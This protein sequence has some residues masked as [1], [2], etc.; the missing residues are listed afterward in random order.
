MHPALRR[1]GQ[2]ASQLMPRSLTNRVFALYTLT[3][4]VF[5]VVGLGLFLKFQFQTEVEDTQAASVMLVEVVTQG[6]QDSVVIGDYDTVRKMLDRAVQGSLF[7]SATFIDMKGGELARADFIEGSC[8]PEVLEQVKADAA[9]GGLLGVRSTPT[10]FVNGVRVVGGL[11]P[12]YLEAV[13][14]YE[15]RKSAK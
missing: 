13:I 2:L 8:S 7:A 1:A 4:A 6:V 14:A 15:L 5:V 11:A 10:F 12:Q 9:L 3:L